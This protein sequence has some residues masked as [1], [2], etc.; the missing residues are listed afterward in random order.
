[1]LKF[2][3][4]GNDLE[5][6]RASVKWFVLTCARLSCAKMIIVGSYYILLLT[7]TWPLIKAKKWAKI[8]YRTK[9]SAKKE[10]KEGL[11]RCV[12]A[13]KVERKAIIN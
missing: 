12:V 2:F 6:L 4:F 13:N 11:K 10:E 8:C 7:E 9:G 1:M 3:A 5:L